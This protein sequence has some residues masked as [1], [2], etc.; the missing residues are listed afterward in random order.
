MSFVF[1]KEDGKP[2]KLDSNT[3]LMLL[4]FYIQLQ[5]R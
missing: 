4:D 3:K 5:I 1:L 2:T